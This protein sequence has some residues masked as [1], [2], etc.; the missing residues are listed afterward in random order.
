MLKFLL[1]LIALILFRPLLID[2][3]FESFLFKFALAFLIFLGLTAISKSQ[4]T[5]TIGFSIAVFSTLIAVI[6]TFFFDSFYLEIFHIILNLVIFIYTTVIITYNLVKAKE[7]DSQMIYG[8]I[9]GYLLI[10]LSGA[11]V[12]ILIE[13]CNPGS[14]SSGIGEDI[15][16]RL[17]YFS[18]V[19][20]STLGYGDIVPLNVF[21]ETVAVL[22]SL[23]GQLYLTVVVALIVGKYIKTKS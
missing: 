7:V 3:G 17:L 4:K 12:F 1:G 20:T 11:L 18:F 2:T 9:S 16:S 15:A 21:A 13:F 23:T 14:F 10:G 5:L 19:T 22:L 8:T 6:D